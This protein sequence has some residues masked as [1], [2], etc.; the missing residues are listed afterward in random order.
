MAA[1]ALGGCDVRCVVCG[2]DGR[3]GQH[4]RNIR[5]LTAWLLAIVFTLGVM[6]GAV[7]TLAGTW[8]W[9]AT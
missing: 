3:R 5:K 9:A 8:I 6:C 4:E 2:R 1:A 7:A